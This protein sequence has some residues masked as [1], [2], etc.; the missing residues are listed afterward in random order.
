VVTN[1][2]PQSTFCDH[3]DA[4]YGTLKGIQSKVPYLRDLGVDIVWLSP[5]YASPNKDMGYDI[6]DYRDID[7]RYGTLQDW[8]ELKDAVHDHGMKLVMDL[9]VNHTSNEV[10]G[11]W[12]RLWAV[13]HLTARMVPGIEVVAG[14]PKTRLV[15]LAAT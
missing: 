8:E 2:D 6:S 7:H 13:T 4:G 15:H 1:T 10:S 9:V 12:S 3:G 11:L 14:Q 5:I